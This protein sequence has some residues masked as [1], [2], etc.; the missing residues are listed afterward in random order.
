MFV[1]G[2]QDFQHLGPLGR[3]SDAAFDERRAHLF[4]PLLD[5]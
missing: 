5:I 1:T 3:D 2:C 4:E